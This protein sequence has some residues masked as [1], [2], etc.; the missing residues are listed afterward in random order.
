MSDK[1]VDWEAAFKELAGL[2]TE[3]GGFIH[4][5]WMDS[6]TLDDVAEPWLVE[7]VAKHTK[8]IK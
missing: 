8:E 1:P 7:L 6:V 3:G 2:F 4:W 5:P